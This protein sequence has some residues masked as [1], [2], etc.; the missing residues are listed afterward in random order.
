MPVTD[1]DAA[2]TAIAAL[3][4]LSPAQQDALRA[5]TAILHNGE[6]FVPVHD[7][8]ALYDTLYFRNLLRPRVELLWSPRLTLVRFS[9]RFM[10]CFL[11]VSDAGIVVRSHRRPTCF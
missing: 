1:Q 4:R 9:L 7:L 10:L 3:D 11:P 2:L 8:F 6:P 5:I